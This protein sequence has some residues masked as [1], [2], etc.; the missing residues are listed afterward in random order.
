MRNVPVLFGKILHH[1]NVNA[2]Y[3]TLNVSEIRS[4]IECTDVLNS[5]NDD[6]ENR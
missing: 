1:W 4:S 3:Q 2:T 6:L 5:L